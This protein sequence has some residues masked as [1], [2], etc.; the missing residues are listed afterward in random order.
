M[1]K[2]K[3]E[4]NAIPLYKIEEIKRMDWLN[5]RQWGKMKCN[6]IPV[7]YHVASTRDTRWVSY[8]YIRKDDLDKYFI[9]NDCF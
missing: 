6:Y 4:R 5:Q 7:I 2:T 3:E 1:A 8:R 9:E